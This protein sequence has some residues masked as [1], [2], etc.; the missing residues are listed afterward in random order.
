[1]ERQN[2]HFLIIHIEA[3]EMILLYNCIGKD[4]YSR[5]TLEMIIL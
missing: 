4:F 5:Y 1:M 3:D 2:K